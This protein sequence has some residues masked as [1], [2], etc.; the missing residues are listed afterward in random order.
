MEVDNDSWETP[1]WLFDQLNEEFNFDI[2]LCATRENSKCSAF[3]LNYLEDIIEDSKGIRRQNTLSNISDYHEDL[4]VFMN[5][6]Y[7]RGSME[8]FIGKV[9]EDSKHCK[10]VCLVKVDSRTKWWS[11][12]Y[13]A[14][15]FKERTGCKIRLLPK[16]VKFDPPN[17]WKGETKGPSFPSAVL[18]FDR[19]VE[20]I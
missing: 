5:P 17:G 16:R 18:I 15:N 2:D 11:I 1:Q 7:S 4:T 6:P 19:R 14:I 8:K 3:Y 20:D 13:D 10:I 12:F 9:W